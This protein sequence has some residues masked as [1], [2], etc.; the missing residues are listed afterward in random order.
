M[1]SIRVRLSFSPQ[2]PFYCKLAPLNNEIQRRM[3]C[4]SGLAL[5]HDSVRHDQLIGVDEAGNH[6]DS[7]TRLRL[8]I[9]KEHPAHSIVQGLE[10]GARAGFVLAALA[11]MAEAI[12][13]LDVAA[14]LP[15][16]RNQDGTSISARLA[17]DIESVRVEP[18]AT[19]KP[20][21]LTIGSDS[22]AVVPTPSRSIVPVTQD[23]VCTADR[24]TPPPTST[25]MGSARRPSFRRHVH[26][27]VAA[28][29]GIEVNCN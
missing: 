21:T 9:G 24:P 25:S 7:S 28:A 8:C 5:M 14:C 1:S 23:A 22:S 29:T 19:V 18:D 13:R 17:R 20:E 12:K 15:E 26:A 10:E 2:H 11:R 6:G 27:A 4:L 3:M 16:G